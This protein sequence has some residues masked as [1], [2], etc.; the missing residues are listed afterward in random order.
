MASRS[1]GCGDVMRF[2]LR[3]SPSNTYFEETLDNDLLESFLKLDD[4]PIGGND[5]NLYEI[6]NSCLKECDKII[7]D[8]STYNTGASHL[9]K[10][11]ITC[12]DDDIIQNEVLR[13][14]SI[15]IERIKRYYDISLKLNSILSPL[16]WELCSGPLPPNDQLKKL[17]SL[18]YQFIKI[19]CFALQFDA[20]K[21]ATPSIQNDLSLYRRIISRSPFSDAKLILNLETA[22]NVCL[23]LAVSSP[24][25]TS[26]VSGTLAFVTSHNDLPI[27]NTTSTLS[28]I[29]H[30]CHGM[31]LYLTEESKPNLEQ[32]NFYAT[33]LVG[34][35]LLYDHIHENGAFIK[36][37]HINIKSIL[38]LL[39]SNLLQ[40]DKKTFLLNTI[41]Y[42]SK[43][44]KDDKT[45]KSIR[46][47]IS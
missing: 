46:L 11:G 41:R 3:Q 42:N 4:I 43:H 27:D 5:I 1:A 15:Y 34:S 17:A 9:V 37:S 36:T 40:D 13:E 18:S 45:S 8:I 35:L 22:N 29:V 2:V 7:E 21:L 31:L 25:F 19:L 10:K 12:V 20:I 14:M 23:F 30:I 24:M 38:E 6:L 26:I 28:S 33:S 44:L 16:L 32:I 47:L 39:H